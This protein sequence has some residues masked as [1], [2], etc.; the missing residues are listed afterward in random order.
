MARKPDIQYVHNFYVHGSEAKVLELKPR[1]K[2]IKTVLPKILPDKSI[3]IPVDPLAM[4]S[5]VVAV[6]LL[7]MMVV[8][9]FQFARASADYREMS[10]KVI[11]LQNEHVRLN[12]KY[13]ESYDI[14][15]IAHMAHSLGMIPAAEAERMYI[16]VQ[17][18]VREAEPTVWENIQW[19]LDGLF[20]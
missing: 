2:I 8:G 1:R 5:C 7:V 12:Q 11:A 13:Q 4:V 6:A 14:E 3:R 17:I 16:D 9:C 20:A 18:P 15:E 19:F 10:G